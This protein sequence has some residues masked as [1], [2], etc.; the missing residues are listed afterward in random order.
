MKNPIGTIS[1]TGDTCPV[2]GEWKAEEDSTT[3]TTLYEGE[4]MPAYFGRS[5]NWELMN[6]A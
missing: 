4:L 6:Y 3:Q 2:T 5:T 1:K